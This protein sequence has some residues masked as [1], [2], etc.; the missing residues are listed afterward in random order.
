MCTRVGKVVPQLNASP[1]APMTVREREMADIKEAEGVEVQG[2]SARRNHAGASIGMEIDQDVTSAWE[3]LAKGE[4][5]IVQL[6]R[7]APR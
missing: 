1:S 2:T 6:V 4:R 3:A 7:I 5:K